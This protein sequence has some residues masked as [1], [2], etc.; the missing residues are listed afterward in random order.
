[1]RVLKI[2]NSIDGNPYLH[3]DYKSEKEVMSNAVKV[4][5]DIHIY[6]DYISAR[7]HVDGVKEIA[8]DIGV[9]Y[10]KL[11]NLL[12][13]VDKLETLMIDS[14]P[15]VKEVLKNEEK[16]IAERQKEKQWKM[17]HIGSPR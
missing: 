3:I 4:A 16:E 2:V 8:Y 5:M 9:Q 14:C 11:S 12:E 13:I 1:M 15:E 6:P 7:M 17:E 10:I